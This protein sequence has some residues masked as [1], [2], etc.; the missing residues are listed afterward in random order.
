MSE[1]QQLPRFSPAQVRRR[2]ILLLG[3]IVLAVVLVT[4]WRVRSDGTPDVVPGPRP[5]PAAAPASA[6]PTSPVVVQRGSG[7][8]EV[9]AGSSN[10]PGRGTVLTVRVEVERGTGVVAQGFAET[11]M[12]TLNDPRSW[13]HGG[14]RTFARTDGPADIR[15]VLA[16][17]DTSAALCRPLVT[18]GRLSC[19]VGDRAV[20]TTYRWQ[21]GADEFSD[22]G[23]YRSYV[24]NHEVGHVLGRPHEGCAGAGRPAPVMQQQTIKVAPCIPNGWPFP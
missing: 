22:L 11:V 2:R 24:V 9:S 13:G 18:R 19:S 1:G 4:T 16:S 12:S 14:D 15:V 6:A 21:G 7:E 17:P 20:I 23:V 8:L 5:A 3:L 10:A